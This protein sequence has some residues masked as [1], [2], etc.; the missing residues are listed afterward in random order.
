MLPSSHPAHRTGCADFPLPEKG[1]RG[2]PREIARPLGKA[3]EAQHF[4][5]RC[6]RKPLGC[7]PHQFVL[8]T[9]TLQQPLASVLLHRPIGFASGIPIQMRTSQ[10]LISSIHIL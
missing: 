9:Q 2:R 7:R 5:Q 3:D 10:H 6:L 4:M 8:G 1:S